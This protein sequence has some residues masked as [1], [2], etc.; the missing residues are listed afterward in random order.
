MVDAK[1]KRRS[2]DA[3]LAHMTAA[4]AAV[5]V[6]KNMHRSG[7]AANATLKEYNSTTSVDGCK[8]INVKKHKTSRQGAAELVAKGMSPHSVH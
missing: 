5:L 7:A 8:V 3:T 6:F 4:L 2:V 1:K